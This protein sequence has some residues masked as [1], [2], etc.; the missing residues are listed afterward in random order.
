[1]E[2]E[3]IATLVRIKNV[4]VRVTRIGEHSL[5]LPK[6][7]TAGSAGYDI[8]SSVDYSV[9]PGMVCKIPTGFSY[10]IPIG[11]FGRVCPRS[12]M[13]LKHSVTVI[14]SPG[15]IDCDYRGEVC[16][17]LINHGEKKL[18]IK[19]GDRIAQIIFEKYYDF[20]ITES[21]ELSI[22]ER[23]IGGFGSTG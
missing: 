3:G 23:G 8:M 4:P 17:L 15:T 7:E 21:K 2:I 6:R 20:D 13:A 18:E 16:V 9:Y 11:F 14:N 19:A 1:M 12:G 10:E 22:T 5:P